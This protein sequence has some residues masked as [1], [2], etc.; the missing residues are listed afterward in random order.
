M[1]IVLDCLSVLPPV[2]NTSLLVNNVPVRVGGLLGNP[3]GD[4]G[5]LSS[6]E[7]F[8]NIV[9]PG[10][11]AIGAGTS[12]IP[13]SSTATM[14]VIRNSYKYITQIRFNSNGYINIRTKATE[15][16]FPSWST[17]KPI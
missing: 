4:K 8:D 7:N 16:N 11:Y 2:G 6:G 12:G 9:K 17:H 13:N 5:S 15:E 10:I 3:L 1:D 14:M